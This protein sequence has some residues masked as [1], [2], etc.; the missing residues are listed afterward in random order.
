[1]DRKIIM[2]TLTAKDGGVVTQGLSL[3]GSLIPPPTNCIL[4]GSHVGASS[5]SMPCALCISGSFSL[6]SGVKWGH[7]LQATSVISCPTPPP[8]GPFPTYCCYSK[9]RKEPSFTPFAFPPKDR[10]ATQ[11]MVLRCY[12]QSFTSS[13][14]LG[15]FLSTDLI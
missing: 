1:M 4:P 8:K 11:S 10:D 14:I 12:I 7:I 13:F 6:F 3:G 15:V 9:H 2:G 5:K